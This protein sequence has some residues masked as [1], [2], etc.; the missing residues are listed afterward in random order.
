MSD[1]SSWS[2]DDEQIITVENV[3]KTKKNDKKDK[4][5]KKNDKKSDKK[6]ENKSEKMI[7]D[8]TDKA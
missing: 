8:Q 6:S 4:K 1:D 3:D 7:I 5:D 2:S